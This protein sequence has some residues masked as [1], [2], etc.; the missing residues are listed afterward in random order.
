MPATPD[1]YAVPSGGA[2]HAGIVASPLPAWLGA[3]ASVTNI[4]GSTFNASGVGAV[5]GSYNGVM[6]YSGGVLNTVGL[7]RSGAFVSGTFLVLFGGGHNDYSGNE[8][9]AYGPLEADAPTWSRITD[10]TSPAPN[11]VAR[12]GA[13][14]PV[15]RHTFDTLVYL[16]AV[17]KML[18]IGSPAAY[19]NATS[20][21][22]A[23]VFDFNIDPA[24]DPWST[25]D[26]GF[27]AYGGGGVATQGLISGYAGGYAWGVGQ[28][29]AQKLGRYNESAGTW[30]S[31]DINVPNSVASQAGDIDPVHEI[32]AWVLTSGALQCIDLRTPTASVYTPTTTG[33]AP[34]GRVA[35]CWDSEGQRFVAWP[36]AGSTLYYLTPPA[37]PYS[38]GDAW[39]WTS[40]S[41]GGDTPTAGG[42]SDHGVYGRAQMVVKP[43][44][45]GL[46]VCGAHDGPI[47]FFRMS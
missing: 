45:R 26:T 21:N 44:W 23:D 18:C 19:S 10:P 2:V 14:I 46:L 39:V 28:G 3:A 9:Y 4:V 27:P 41:F 16:P 22:V 17:N 32:M 11:N 42:S 13:G 6:A 24:G 8:L 35:M 25:A 47:T 37:D 30:S 38:G 40:Q 15:S 20:F 12:D 7:W 29:N 36:N 33:T 5:A 34:T 43:A 31:W 1:T